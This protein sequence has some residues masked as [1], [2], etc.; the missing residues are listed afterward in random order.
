MV[1]RW[2]CSLRPVDCR[3][4]APRVIARVDGRQDWV[5]LVRMEITKLQVGTDILVIGDVESLHGFPRDLRCRSGA[6]GVLR[7]M[8]PDAQA[9]RQLRRY[10]ASRSVSQP[11]NL[12][13]D[14]EILDAVEAAIENGSVQ[15]M[16]LPEHG[17]YLRE[18]S[19]T[20]WGTQTPSVGFRPHS[21][22]V[23]VAS[24]V[25]T[26]VRGGPTQLVR[27]AT[28]RPISQMT[29]EERIWAIIKRAAAILPQAR[30]AALM[31]LFTPDNIA[32]AAALTRQ[33][34]AADQTPLG[35][36]SDRVFLAIAFGFGGM[37][38]I[39]GLKDLVAC[40][41][42]T[43]EAQ[44][45]PDLDEAAVFLSRVVDELGVACLIAILHEQSK[46]G[47]A[48]GGGDSDDSLAQSRNG[49]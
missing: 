22:A 3:L 28:T 26:A 49:L 30:G 19:A 5:L 34:A 9:M 1:K 33:S 32:V 27:P 15:A 42:L 18:H 14:H 44:S 17:P 16:V 23:P 48:G 43:A 36:S 20:P 21:L 47:K 8:L 37:E 35:W 40:F 7:R 25:T 39:Q 41:R 10:W 24:T 11:M 6:C 38:A 12:N 29:I 4:A 13:S 31:G 45:E 46:R 2:P